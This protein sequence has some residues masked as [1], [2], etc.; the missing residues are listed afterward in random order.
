MKKFL[1]SVFLKK[2]QLIYNL[3]LNLNLY[4]LNENNLKFER[5]IKYEQNGK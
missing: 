5:M 3:N 1:K 2:N 4:K